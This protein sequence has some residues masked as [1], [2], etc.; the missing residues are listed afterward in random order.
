MW[1][2]L[3]ESGDL[4]K[5]GSKYLIL[6]MLI[7]EDID[8]LDNLIKSMKKSLEK[9]KPGRMYLFK[10]DGE[11]KYSNFPDKELLRRSLEAIAAS[12]TKIFAVY[13]DKG[14]ISKNIEMEQKELIFKYLLK[15]ICEKNFLKY[16]KNSIK[17]KT[18]KG[19]DDSFKFI[20]EN[21]L[22]RIVADMSFL[23]KTP[24]KEKI[25]CLN[26]T[27][28]KEQ[29]EVFDVEFEE[30][31]EENTKTC[32]VVVKVELKNSGTNTKLQA[33]DIVCGA[34]YDFLENKKVENYLI[35]KEKI[36]M[37]EDITKEIQ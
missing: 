22:T 37:F 27:F 12:N 36:R 28:D 9:H 7:T 33:T 35:L 3:D 21:L 34:I 4:G 20:R 10:K 8:Y 17:E 26:K 23:K 5:K 6:T 13:I 24:K 11:I 31:N 29:G 18:S 15:Y 14:K 2:F 16:E 30:V 19:I 25:Y 32:H 1:A